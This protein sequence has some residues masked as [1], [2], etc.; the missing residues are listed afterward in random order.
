MGITDEIRESHLPTASLFTGTGK[1]KYPSKK[2]SHTRDNDKG[3][4]RSFITEKLA[5]KL[6]LKPN[7]SDTIS[8]AYFGGKSE[9]YRHIPT[10][11]V[12]LHVQHREIIPLDV[13]IVPTIAV[14]LPNLQ[15][16]V[17]CLK[18]IEGLKLAH[19]ITDIDDDFEISLLIG[20]DYF[21]QIVQNKVVRGNGPTAVKSKLGYL[22]S[23]PLPEV[24]NASSVSYMFNVVTAP[25]NATDLER[26]WKLESMG[27]LEDD[28]EKSTSGILNEYK[29][30]C[31]TY[32][33]GR[34]VAKLPWKEDHSVLPTN[35]EIC[36]KRTEN[37]IKRL[38]IETDILKN[39]GQIIED[40]L[41]RGFIEKCDTNVTTSNPV[42]LIPH[43]YV[44]KDS[45]T[46]PI[47]IVY[48]CSCKSRDQPSLNDCLM[49]TPPELNDLIG[50]LIRFRMNK[51]AIATDIEKAFLNITLDENDRD[52][53]RFLWLSDPSNPNSELTTYRFR[54]VL[55]GATSSPFILCATI[56]KHLEL[57][58]DKKASK[59]LRQDLDVDNV[60]S[61]FQQE[62]QLL[63]FYTESRELMSS[64]GFNLRSWSS[65]SKML[66]KQAIN[67]SV[68]DNAQTPKILGMKWDTNSDVLL[69]PVRN[70]PNTQI[71]TKREILQ[72]T[73]RIYDP[74]GLLNQVT[75]RAKLLLQELWQQKFEWDM[76]LPD[77][78]QEKW[79]SLIT[80]LNSV[81]KT[82]FPRYYFENT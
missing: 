13:L 60:I 31:I 2:F 43:H 38:S 33:D 58:N 48:D 66:Q 52:V 46:T 76:P 59:Y 27:I 72:H 70:I 22:L 29:E 36:K 23:G 4:Q 80:D 69:Y 57:N 1:K 7:G 75:I 18:Y 54:A 51:Y 20:A 39:Y 3:A 12:F 40:Q 15:R 79:R 78:I 16:N 42:H 74:L 44:K 45:N 67:D 24:K 35:Y 30:N 65:N 19:R 17:K 14:P 6:K 21:W 63:H 9:Q 53:T 34:Y 62:E 41:K 5:E 68:I 56:L 32:K 37:T 82:T 61:S 55:F 10:G 71:V 28:T 11:R 47:R 8:L 73:S 49:S 64:A 50:I 26:F 25:P 81:T 77:S